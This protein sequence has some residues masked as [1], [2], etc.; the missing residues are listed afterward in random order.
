MNLKDLTYRQ[1]WINKHVGTSVY[2]QDW[3][4]F[5]W[6]NFQ[7]HCPNKTPD[8]IMFPNENGVG[9]IINISR[10]R[11]GEC[12][13]VM[14]ESVK[15][16]F[17][18]VYRILTFGKDP[19]INFYFTGIGYPIIMRSPGILIGPNFYLQPPTINIV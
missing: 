15:D 12:K 1:S 5:G 18:S 13:E 10:A 2:Y 14:P 7:H 16:Y 19:Y 3:E 11:C 6:G 8:Q 9:S 17:L 4:M